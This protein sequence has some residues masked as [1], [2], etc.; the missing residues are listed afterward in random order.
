MQYTAV[1]TFPKGASVRPDPHTKN[2]SLTVLPQG[3]RFTFETL[4]KIS[5]LEEWAYAEAC[6]ATP[7]GWIALR[8]PGN[9]VQRADYWISGS[10]IPPAGL[11]LIVHDYQLPPHYTARV[12]LPGW[13]NPNMRQAPEVFPFHSSPRPNSKGARTNMTKLEAFLRHLN[14]TKQKFNYLI[15]PHSGWFN[16]QGWPK[17]ERLAMGGNM[18][19]VLEEERGYSRIE[20]IRSDVAPNPLTVTP[21]RTPWL[22][23]RFN[24][25][26]SSNR[27]IDPPPGEIYCPIAVPFGEQVWIPSNLL[28]PLHTSGFSLADFQAMLNNL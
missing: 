9:L 2:I 22:I 28:A 3:S 18:V 15:N 4:L 14:P 13:K 26:T 17:W 6:G 7:A 11:R 1:V 12:N 8:Y 27:S 21:W 25:V 20:S 10:I 19:N 23:Q 24:V 16:N 5:G